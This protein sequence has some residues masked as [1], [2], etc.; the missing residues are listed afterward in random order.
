[1]LLITSCSLDTNVKTFQAKVDEVE[2]ICSHPEA[3]KDHPI[4]EQFKSACVFYACKNAADANYGKYLEYKTFIEGLKGNGKAHSTIIHD[5]TKCANPGSK[6]DAVIFSVEPSST[7]YLNEYL[8]SQPEVAIVRANGAV[9]KI[10]APVTLS[11]HKNATCSDSAISS[12]DWSTASANPVNTVDGK[13]LYQ[14]LKFLQLGTYYLKA[15]SPKLKSA[16]SVA[17]VITENLGIGKKV[18]F[19]NPKPSSEALHSRDLAVQ[20]KVAIVNAVGDVLDVDNADIALSLFSDDKCLINQV[21]TWEANANPVKTLDGVSEFGGVAINSGGTFYFRATSGSLLQDCYGPVKVADR[22]K[23]SQLP[24]G[25]VVK[26]VALAQQ[27]IVA[28]SHQDNTVAPFNNVAVK[29][30]VYTDAQCSV[31]ADAADYE[32]TT[33]PVNSNGSGLSAFSGVKFL[34]EAKFYLRGESSPLL[35]TACVPVDVG[36]NVTKVKFVTPLPTNKT[37]KDTLFAQ[38]PKVALVDAQDNVIPE[39]GKSVLLT[40]HSDNACNSTSV[41][42]NLVVTT[43]P[44]QTTAGYYQYSGVKIEEG[45]IYFLK[46]SSPGVEGTCYGP[47]EIAQKLILEQSTTAQVGVPLVE[48]P[49]VKVSLPNNSVLPI[50]GVPVTYKVYTDAQ[51]SNLA[52]NPA[53]WSM[54]SS[55]PVLT[56]AAGIAQFS[57]VVINAV[58]TF[59]SKATTSDPLDASACL[60]INTSAIAHT[61]AF[62][63]PYIPAA[64]VKNKTYVPQPTVE[65]RDASGNILPITIP[66]ELS[67]HTNSDCSSA[68]LSKGA[69]NTWDVDATP[70]Q[71]TN[72]KITFA[73]FKVFKGGKYYL[74]AKTSSPGV[75]SACS[76]EFIVAD[77]LIF[78]PHGPATIVQ[79][80]PATIDTKVQTVWKV[81]QGVVQNAPVNGENVTISVF[82]DINCSGAPV[83]ATDW[84]FTTPNP[85]ASVNGDSIFS[86]LVLKKVGKYYLKATSPNLDPV[87]SSEINVTPA[88]TK[89]VFLDPKPSDKGTADKALEKQPKVQ[90]VDDAGN[91]VLGDDQEIKISVT[92]DSQCNQEIS[93]A[94]YSVDAP[95]PA[96]TVQGMKQFTGLKIKIGGLFYIRASGTGL[97]PACYGPVEIADALTFLVQPH[98]PNMGSLLDVPLMTSTGAVRPVNIHVAKSGI[99]ITMKIYLDDKCETTPYAED[100]WK[101]IDPVLPGN[102]AVL[103]TDASGKSD[104]KK[105]LFNDYGSYY[106]KITSPGLKPACSEKFE[107]KPLGSSGC[108]EKLAKNYDPNA[109]KDDCSCVFEFCP[110]DKPSPDSP[111]AAYYSYP[112][113][114]QCQ[115]VPDF[116]NICGGSCEE[117][118][119][120]VQADK[121]KNSGYFYQCDKLKEVYDLHCSATSSLEC[122][123]LK[124]TYEGCYRRQKCSKLGIIDD[125]KAMNVINK[126]HAEHKY[127]F[128]YNIPNAIIQSPDRW[129]TNGYPT[130]DSIC[131]KMRYPFVPPNQSSEI[132]QIFNEFCD[133]TDCDDLGVCNHPDAENY[134]PGSG[135][136]SGTGSGAGSLVITCSNLSATA[137]A[138]INDPNSFACFQHQAISRYCQKKS[139]CLSTA[140]SVGVN[141]PLCFTNPQVYTCASACETQE[142][143]FWFCSQAANQGSSYCQDF[144]QYYGSCIKTGQPP[145]NYNGVYPN[146]G[147][148]NVNPGASTC[149]NICY[150]NTTGMGSCEETKKFVDEFCGPQVTNVAQAEKCNQAKEFLKFC[151]NTKFC[152]LEK[153]KWPYQNLLALIAALP[154]YA[155]DVNTCNVYNMMWSF[156]S[157]VLPNTSPTQAGTLEQVV[158]KNFY[159]HVKSCAAGTN[160]TVGFYNLDCSNYEYYKTQCANKCPDSSGGNEN[161]SF[162]VCDNAQWADTLGYKKYLGYIEYCKKANISCK[163]T[164]DDSL[165]VGGGT[166]TCEDRKNPVQADKNRNSG[167]IHQCDKFKANYEKFCLTTTSLACTVHQ[168]NYEACYRRANCSRLGLVDDLAALLDLA[169]FNASPQGGGNLSIFNTANGYFSSATSINDSLD[170]LCIKMRYPGNREKYLSSGQT[171][172]VRMYD[173]YCDCTECE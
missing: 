64:W 43:N 151:D 147:C 112:N 4:C 34:K 74:K 35:P 32:V 142:A 2:D 118:A 124:A 120:P 102:N 8:N 145:A 71:T 78:N 94:D 47:I 45:G 103:S 61:L 62:G 75:Q 66:V 38:Q 44:G 55:N 122:N 128:L 9:A 99:P 152:D 54:T 153:A 130:F 106:L 119:N 166:G 11:V 23:F 141:V 172:L 148:N 155:V 14:N 168:Q 169:A 39:N 137:Q 133:C 161:C 24:S 89:I 33:N 46:V 79:N 49:K 88:S 86:G 59:Y 36:S 65:A 63:E 129:P 42:S 149:P 143:P 96:M 165:C 85:K 53:Q 132:N 91:P 171:E 125:V 92:S 70:N 41:N 84:S 134:N 81:S 105:F 104:F 135:A 109:I 27:P 60:P 159:D 72:G 139:T 158:C 113:N 80:K 115:K 12:A 13:H 48:Q 56:N 25:V 107:I 116:V 93:S 40:L 15:A 58:G 19:I 57:G 127:I 82:K 90:L 146:L 6:L 68:A 144:F 170:T 164:S 69:G 117:K 31:A 50:A 97:E 126:L 18:V 76:F 77:T 140:A 154:T 167:Y 26:G 150:K 157:K 3:I 67:L 21:N 111:Q 101:V 5:S 108:T 20:P 162:R 95:N 51:C 10:S 73:G 160:P 123:V 110:V 114:K 100:K 28:V 30:G 121:N 83:P 1:M 52:T 138:C 156:C 136:G 37:L 163:F 98:T 87:C 17:I 16:C 22:L 7:G 29:L 131:F 173:K